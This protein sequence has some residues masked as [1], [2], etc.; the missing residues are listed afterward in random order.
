MYQDL[1]ATPKKEAKDRDRDI[2]EATACW[3]IEENVP[4]NMVEKKSFRQMC[5]SLFSG[6]P[7]ITSSQ[8][9]TEIKSLGDV[10]KEAVQMELQG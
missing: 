3:V 7:V 5:T 8:V 6:A 10:C 9:R 2:L 1:K 4:F